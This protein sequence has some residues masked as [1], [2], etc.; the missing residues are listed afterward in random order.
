MGTSEFALPS[1]R[2]L[3]SAGHAI[4][5]VV[6]RPDRPRERRGGAPGPT[7][8]KAA[9]AAAGRPVL[10]P[11]S[12]RDP[13]FVETLRGLAPETIVVAAYGQ[14]LPPEVL[15]IPPRFCINVHASLLPRH[16]GAAPVARAILADDRVTGVTTMRMDRGLDTG[17]ILLQEECAIG[18]GETCGELTARLAERGA[19]LV[20][21]TLARLER[22]E[23]EPRRQ[24][25]REATLAPALTRDDG[26]IDW[27]APAE[28]IANRVRACNPWPAAFAMLRDR[29]VQILRAE[30]GFEP[31]A[32]PPGAE[33]GRVI[34]AA[35]DRILVRCG[36]D[37]RLAIL[38][39]RVPGRRAVSAR[40][41]IN[42][43]LVAAGDRFGPA[44]RGRGPVPRGRG[45]AD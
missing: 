32:T 31:V 18:L 14:I 21:E 15:A 2:A 25:A 36:G 37:V 13:G 4:A 24:D 20:V 17:D 44:P 7:P 42:G 38:E 28:A 3:A 34:A 10:E 1:L 40:D 35:G 23:L 27:A 9:A 43:R 6:T 33:P 8:V 41:A 5:A 16:R 11:E 26:R 22:G 30:P 19:V 45:P 39:L 12:A 29:V